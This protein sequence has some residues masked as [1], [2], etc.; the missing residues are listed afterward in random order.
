MNNAPL[1][2]QLILTTLAGKYLLA[3]TATQAEGITKRIPT[4]A[5][6]LLLTA[7]LAS[8][9]AQAEG[10]N[11]RLIQPNIGVQTPPV[12]ETAGMTS[13][14]QPIK[15]PAI[16]DAGAQGINTQVIAPIEPTKSALPTA[17]GLPTKIPTQP[18]SGNLP[19]LKPMTAPSVGG[20]SNTGNT[21]LQPLKIVSTPGTSSLAGQEV[22]I[23]TQ[24]WEDL[25]KLPDSTVFIL[26]DGKRMT[27]NEAKQ[28]R[29]QIQQRVAQLK[30]RL[31]S[32][33]NGK[34]L[35]VKA[36]A[37]TTIDVRAILQQENAA[38]EAAISKVNQSGKLVTQ[39]NPC[40]SSIN[41]KAV[42]RAVFTPGTG[43]TAAKVT[44]KGGG[45]GDGK[46][47]VYLT[48]AFNNRPSLRVDTWRDDQIVAYFQPGY[49]GELDRDSVALVIN[50]AGGKQIS[51]A[52]SAKF[53]ATR[54]SQTIDFSK[55]PDS[56]IK[57]DDDSRVTMQRYASGYAGGIN[58]PNGLPN[59]NHTFVDMIDLTS[60][61]LFKNGFEATAV[62]MIIEQPPENNSEA[63]LPG[64]ECSGGAYKFGD[65]GLDWVGDS[66]RIKRPMG[67]LHFSASSN[68]F[69]ECTYLTGDMYSTS[70][71]DIQITV[72]GPA[73]TSPL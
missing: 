62:N 31:T 49:A 72:T 32:S 22:R 2:K 56:R 39:C 55:I 64:I 50:T 47:E 46:P 45:F 52:A 69:S 63:I 27:M 33:A 15:L 34:K 10:I 14:V 51:T 61:G 73:G 30:N 35:N 60:N 65:S 23:S 5:V 70:V 9:S 59:M 48:G 24:K 44:I 18:I 41:G 36:T 11:K 57:F 66:L 4:S 42:S 16:N 17:T 43:N 40:I 54:V 53:Y 19:A 38:A 37:H 21:G 29:Q 28:Q 12:A 8:G 26:P 25:Q 67:L 7:L 1:I 13:T 58:T 71:H 20:V 6:S 3:N 68:P